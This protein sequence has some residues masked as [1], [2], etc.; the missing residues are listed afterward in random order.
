[1]LIIRKIIYLLLFLSIFTSPVFA[2]GNAFEGEA[3]SDYFVSLVAF[4]QGRDIG[5]CPNIEPQLN[6]STPTKVVSCDAALKDAFLET[7]RGEGGLLAVLPDHSVHNQRGVILW[8]EM[9][10]NASSSTGTLTEK[11]ISG[12]H[13]QRR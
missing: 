11:I 1:M 4:H 6:I 13:S 2:T 8:D 3:R 10:K 5:S 9:D 12:N 7:I